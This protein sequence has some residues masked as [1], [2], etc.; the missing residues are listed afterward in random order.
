MSKINGL[1]IGSNW[2][3]ARISKINGPVMNWLPSWT[4]RIWYPFFQPKIISALEWIPSLSWETVTAFPSFIDHNGHAA[5]PPCRA[6]CGIK[7]TVLRAPHE[8]N[9]CLISMICAAVQVH[10]SITICVRQLCCKS[11][12][13][14]LEGVEL[15]S[16][17]VPGDGAKNWMKNNKGHAK[18]HVKWAE[19]LARCWGVDAGDLIDRI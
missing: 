18:L 14:S 7:R 15:H 13:L 4:P 8:L 1:Y 11:S 3:S 2:S 16:S 17:D 12:A 19:I 9:K 10:P 5:T 6:W